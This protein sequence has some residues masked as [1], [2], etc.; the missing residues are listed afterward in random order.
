MLAEI[1]RPRLLSKRSPT[2]AAVYRG[3]QA[4]GFGSMPHLP[5]PPNSSRAFRRGRTIASMI[6]APL[7]RTSAMATFRC[8]VFWPL[9]GVSRL[10]SSSQSA[11]QREALVHNKNRREPTAL[12]R[13]AGS[14]S[15]ASGTARSVVARPQPLGEATSA[16]WRRSAGPE[17][18]LATA[19][20]MQLGVGGESCRHPLCGRRGSDIGT[21]RGTGK[22]AMRCVPLAMG[23]DQHPSFEAVRQLAIPSPGDRVGRLTSAQPVGARRYVMTAST[24]RWSSGDSPMSSFWKMCPT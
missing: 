7:Q 2:T 11:R 16:L 22:M 4:R 14:R 20:L 5:R 3:E 6:G 21:A 13:L 12:A 10:A 15:H 17:R 1:S 19:L 18:R 24:R 9:A 23:P 8:P